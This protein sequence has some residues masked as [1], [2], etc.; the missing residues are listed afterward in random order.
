MTLFMSLY[1]RS[2][3]RSNRAIAAQIPDL[4]DTVLSALAAQK[5]RSYEGGGKDDP[6]LFLPNMRDDVL[7]KYHSLS[8]R[9]QIWTRVRAVVEQNSNVRTGQREGSNGEVGR[10]WEWIGPSGAIEGNARRR[11]RV[12]RSADVDQEGADDRAAIHKRWDEPGS[13]PVY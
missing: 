12:S 5:E 13:R 3:Y 11:G 4:V 6:F 7:R 1:G 8:K 9:E 2:R 10:A